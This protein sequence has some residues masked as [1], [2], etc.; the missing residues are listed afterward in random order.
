M[1]SEVRMM[2]SDVG[3]MHSH[4]RMEHPD[5]G[6]MRSEACQVEN[7]GRSDLLEATS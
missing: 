3:M 7:V 5:V 2:Q 1:Q 4:V 6:M